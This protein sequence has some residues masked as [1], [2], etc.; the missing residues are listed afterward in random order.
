[1]SLRQLGAKVTARGV[2]FGAFASA[3]RECSV[4][5]FDPARRAQRTLPLEPLGAG[6]FALEVPGLSAGALYKLVLDG[7]ELPDPYARFLP[8]GVHG[9]A[10]VESSEHSFRNARPAPMPLAR[11]VIYEL[12]VGTFTKEGTYRAAQA[13]LPYLA[14]LGVTTIELMPLSSFPG[15][16]GWGYDGVAHFAPFAAYGSPDELRDFVDEAHG[17]GLRVLL[18]VVYNH[19]G[20]AGNYL[21]AYSDRYFT[22][23]LHTPWGEAPRFAEAPMRRYV[24]DNALY[25]LEEFRFDGLRLDATHAIVDPS[26]QHVLHDL[27]LAVRAAIPGALL[28]V[29]DERNEPE[30]VTKLGFDAIW[31]DDFHHQLRVT[32]TGERDG[33]YAGY[34]PGVE[35]LARVIERG[36]LYEGQP[37]PTNGKPRGRPAEQ[38]EPPAFVYCIQNHDQIGNRAL[39]QRLNHEVSLDAYCL[40]SVLLLFLPMTPLLFMGQEWA[41]STPFLFFTAHDAEL[42]AHVTAG[43]RREFAHFAAFSEPALQQA[44]PDPQG[45]E[46]FR[47]S[48]LDWDEC[49]EAAHARVGDLYRRLLKL[50]R[51]DEILNQVARRADVRVRTHGSVLAVWRGDPAGR[52]GRLLLAN[53]GSKRV[54]L[55]ELPWTSP[56][57]SRI[58]S[59]SAGDESERALSA[60]G[61][62]IFRADL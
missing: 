47:R 62:A 33:Y 25:W 53:F 55:H 12:H 49:T 8:D 41:A 56:L 42:G 43:R 58:F 1:V 50:R 2:Q 59:L 28:I 21:G 39:G 60:Y 10:R 7:Q 51:E 16:R 11:Q 26:E 45:A 31:A 40:A 17:L 23:D 29:E 37:F 19:F 30:C 44:I 24:L 35:G 52:P 3:A 15:A 18:D 27:V 4:R 34:E 61:A 54:P 6:Y 32:L 48:K 9:V 14:E 38:L 20:P 13:R 36:W 22:S 46:T 5:L 57:E